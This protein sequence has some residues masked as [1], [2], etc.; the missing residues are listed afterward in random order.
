MNHV[1]VTSETKLISTNGDGPMVLENAATL[2]AALSALG[3]VPIVEIVIRTPVPTHK[4]FSA[5]DLP[6]LVLTVNGAKAA[7]DV[8]P[9][10]PAEVEQATIT[11]D[12]TPAAAQ[13]AETSWRKMTPDQRQDAALRYLNGLYVRLGHAP[14]QMEYHAAKP[15][16]MPTATPLVALFGMS[17]PDLVRKACPS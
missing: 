4:I 5:A 3:A 10:T 11:P 13:P 14:T 6:A 1:T 2:Y 7:Q 15:E 17:W 12:P 8:R 9:A 16:W